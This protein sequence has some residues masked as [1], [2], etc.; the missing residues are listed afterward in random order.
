MDDLNKFSSF[1]FD[2]D[3]KNIII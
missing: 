2:K 1:K 3:Q